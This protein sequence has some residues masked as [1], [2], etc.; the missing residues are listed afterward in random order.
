[1]EPERPKV[2]TS[3]LIV[4]DGRV[5][6]GMRLNAHGEGQYAFPGGHLEH[7]ESVHACVTREIAEE[8]GLEVENL[9]FLRALNLKA[10]APKHYVDIGMIAE[11]KA[12]EPQ[13]LEPSKCAGWD[14]YHPDALPSPRFEGVDQA[15][16]AWKTGRAFFDA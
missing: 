3:V 2:G 9:R 12:G 10:Y 11:W 15:V 1:M 16:E 14:W 7:M 13:V 5:L 4:K 8:C 6:L